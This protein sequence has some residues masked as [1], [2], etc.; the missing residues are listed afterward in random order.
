MESFECRTRRRHGAVPTYHGV[1]LATAP[2]GSARTD[3]A[4]QHRLARGRDTRQ[5]VRKAGDLT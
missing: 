3:L 4:L 5:E 2:T 1:G